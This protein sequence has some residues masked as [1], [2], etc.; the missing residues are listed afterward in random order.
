MDIER[1]RDSNGRGD[2]GRSRGEGGLRMGVR[3]ING[4]MAGLTS[5]SNKETGF[6]MSFPFILPSLSRTFSFSLIP[7]GGLFFFFAPP[8]LSLLTCVSVLVGPPLAFP[9]LFLLFLGPRF[10]FLFFP[11]GL[12]IAGEVSRS[13]EGDIVLVESLRSQ[14]LFILRDTGLND[15]D[16]D[17][18]L[19]SPSGDRGDRELLYDSGGDG[20][21]GVLGMPFFFLLLKT[22]DDDRDLSDRCSGKGLLL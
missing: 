22:G 7:F 11:R 2:G 4:L 17:R 8:L 12:L 1:P 19:D 20:S 16:L 6:D 21:D 5:M 14:S 3:S 13:G 9:P 15:L 10:R 18:D